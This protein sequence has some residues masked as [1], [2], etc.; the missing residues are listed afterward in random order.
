MSELSLLDDRDILSKR[1][2][3][4]IVIGCKKPGETEEDSAHLVQELEGLVQSLGID[5]VYSMAAAIKKPNPKYYVGAGKVAE[6]S[7]HIQA[8]N[9]DIV[10]FDDELSPSQQR[11]LEKSFKI[12]VIDRH[13]VILDIFNDRAR[14]NEARLQVALAQMEYNLP[15]LRKAWTHLSRQ[16]GGTRGTRG[17]G[18]KQLEADRRIVLNKISKLKRKLDEVKQSRATQRKKR[19]SVPMPTAS[20][21]GYTNAG[22]SCLLNYLTNARTLVEDKLF[23]T[24]DPTTRKIQF[25][26]GQEMLLTDT[27]GFVRKLPHDLIEAFKSTLEETLNADFLIHVADASSPEFTEH[28]RTTEKVLDE[29]GAGDK[30]VVL[31][32]NKA[33]KVNDPHLLEVLLPADITAEAIVTVSVLKQTGIEAL[34]SAIEDQLNKGLDLR[35]FVFPNSRYDLVSLVHRHGHVIDEQY[36]GNSIIVKAKVTA[37]LMTK[38]HEYICESPHTA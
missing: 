32:L 37:A 19:E 34:V 12:T 30:P 26:N 18:E 13:E 4:A 36:E 6:I 27:V 21:V 7:S 3:K 33:D 23:A 31:V 11:N 22:K 20:I 28:I 16:R 17:E 24:L 9:A 38:L 15:R 35:R 25:P 14:T 5:V 1:C 10:V 29:I 8:Y 2:E